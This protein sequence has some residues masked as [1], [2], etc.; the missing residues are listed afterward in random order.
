MPEIWTRRPQPDVWD[1]MMRRR[2]GDDEGAFVRVFREKEAG[3]GTEDPEN[4]ERV[5]QPEG[6]AIEVDARTDEEIDRRGKELWEQREKEG[7][8]DGW[9][10]FSMTGYAYPDDS[11]RVVSSLFLHVDCCLSLRGQILPAPV[12]VCPQ[13]SAKI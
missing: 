2:D 12:R 11:K 3:L 6:K 1:A 7:L 13:S 10:D 5:W 9:H 8:S 4:R